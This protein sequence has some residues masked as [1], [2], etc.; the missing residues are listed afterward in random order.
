MTN[1]DFYDYNRKERKLNF[2]ANIGVI[3]YFIH[4][5]Y[6]LRMQDLTMLI[7]LASFDKGHFTKEYFR[8]GMI[9]ASYDGKKFYRMKR[10]GWI[11]VARKREGGQ[12]KYNI[13]KTTSKTNRM[14]DRIYSLLFGEELI[15]ES[16]QGNRIFRQDFEGNKNQ[17]L[18]IKR[19]NEEMRMRLKDK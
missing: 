11:E 19:L 16:H 10:E 18:K 5:H 12:R 1:V 15:P 4:R 13:Y 6:Q 17:R 3:L 8:N 2:L 9:A 7:K 14:V